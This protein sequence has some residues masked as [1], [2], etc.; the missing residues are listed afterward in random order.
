VEAAQVTVRSVPEWRSRY[1]HL[2]HLMM[3]RGRKIVMAR[4]LAIRLYWMWRK[5]WDYEQ[6][7]KFG[8][9]GRKFLLSCRHDQGFDSIA[10]V[11]KFADHSISAMSSC[12]CTHRGTSLFVTHT[13][14][15]NDPDE[16]AKPMG[17][18]PDRLI[19]SQARYQSAIEDLENGSFRLGR[20]VGSLI[21]NAP[22][23]AITLRG[24]VTLGYFCTFFLARACS[25]PCL[26][27]A[28]R[29]IEFSC[30]DGD[31]STVCS[32]ACEVDLKSLPLLCDAGIRFT[33]LLGQMF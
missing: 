32:S 31:L 22:H 33:K 2:F 29:L 11:P 18:G 30:N 7:T 25:N 1:F 13:A 20:G 4:R 23:V 24:T 26:E 16:A 15:E 14:M 21:Q 5:Q 27:V 12:F 3:R 6:M 19:V 10:K 28:E 9:Q 8:S 17:N